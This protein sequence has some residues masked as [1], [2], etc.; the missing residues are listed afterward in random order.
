MKR[1][2]P[3]IINLI[4]NSN[5]TYSHII[6]EIHLKFKI[7]I[8]KSTISYYKQSKPR[9]KNVNPSDIQQWKWDWLFGLYFADGCKFTEKNYAYTVKFSLDANR[10]LDIAQRVISLIQKLGLNPVIYKENNLL[11]IRV[12]SKNLYNLFPSKLGRYK[13]RNIFSFLSGMIDGD[14]WINN[15][16]MSAYIGQDNNKELM[17][18]LKCFLRLPHHVRYEIRWGNPKRN[19]FYIP[20]EISK[21]LIAYK[22]SV[23]L[24]R[25]LSYVDKTKFVGPVAQA[26]SDF[27]SPKAASS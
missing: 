15:K 11:A 27:L 9:T 22:Y 8:S 7:K 1:L 12:F 10:D 18:Y 6:K 20:V 5:K 3:D 25:K 16:S 17:I 13:P 19:I 4:K 21:V 14:G 24:L 26:D 23:K 2:S